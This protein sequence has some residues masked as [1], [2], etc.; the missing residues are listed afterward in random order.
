MDCEKHLDLYFT[1][2]PLAGRSRTVL[3]EGLLRLAGNDRGKAQQMLNQAPVKIKTGLDP[4]AA[5][6]WVGH[7]LKCG[8]HGEI[9]RG[10][11]AIYQT[12]PSSAAA[13]SRAG[14]AL[15]KPG[16]KRPTQA[17]PSVS[18]SKPVVASVPVSAPQKNTV[19]VRRVFDA[20]RQV[21]LCLP[22]DWHPV[23]H[24]N[25]NAIMQFAHQQG[26]VY[27]IVIRQDKQAFDNKVRL[28]EYAKAVV[29]AAVGWVKSGKASGDLNRLPAEGGYRTELA[30][31]AGT[32][33]V[34]YQISVHESPLHFYCV[35]LWTAAE[36]FERHA[37]L[38]KS[39]AAS[40]SARA[41]K[42]GVK[43]KAS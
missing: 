37:A 23:R 19:K 28:Q 41:T 14:A 11:K 10:Q 33:P 18:A 31:L 15:A 26:G 17:A 7:L 3:S 6:Q 8:W 30:G 25:P 4:A 27:L 29:S 40:F 34:R 42:T 9:R 38:F 20:D 16:A 21:S 1:G 32:V 24:L 22:V 35:Y 12:Q 39:L 13:A 5:R 2:K 43:V 36:E